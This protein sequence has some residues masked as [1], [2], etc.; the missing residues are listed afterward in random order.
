[1][2]EA[3]IEVRVVH[4]LWCVVGGGGGGGRGG[5]GGHLSHADVCFNLVSILAVLVD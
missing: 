2:T 4:C 5:G 3:I 1:V